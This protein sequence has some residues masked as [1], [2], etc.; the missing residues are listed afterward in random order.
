MRM[1]D[2][3]KKCHFSS[4]CRLRAG[5]VSSPQNSGQLSIR[6]LPPSARF[7]LRCCSYA[8]AARLAWFARP[9]PSSHRLAFLFLSRL[10]HWHRTRDSLPPHFLSWYREAHPR[11][12][13]FPIPARFPGPNL[14][15]SL[16]PQEFFPPAAVPPGDPSHISETIPWFR[17][18]GN[19]DRERRRRFSP[20]ASP[21]GADILGIH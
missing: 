2:L 3:S 12:S 16:C 20:A 7:V 8:P 6:A 11:A 5:R 4:D 13:A 1:A 17:E 14:C 9:V 19:A 18:E 21:A 10:A 15:P